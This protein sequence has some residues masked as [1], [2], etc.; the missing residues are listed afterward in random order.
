MAVVAV[1]LLTSWREPRDNAWH[2]H[3]CERRMLVTLQRFAMEEL[4]AYRHFWGISAPGLWV[5][6]VEIRGLGA[7]ENR[8]S[9]LGF[10]RPA[11]TR[12]MIGATLSGRTTISCGD[13]VH[14]WGP[15]KV[16]IFPGRG[17][18]R[19]SIAAS[20]EVLSSII[21]ETDRRVFPAP[22]APST[23][24]NFAAST[25]LRGMLGSLCR[26]IE[27]AWQSGLPTPEARLPLDAALDDLLAFLWAE[28]VLASRIQAR[29]LPAIPLRMR[30]VG[31]AVDRALSLS[32]RPM[33][34]DMEAGSAGCARTLQRAFP[35]LCEVWGQQPESFRAY[36][37]RLVLGR[38]L[39]AMM[40]PRATTMGVASA[41]GFSSPSAFCRAVTRAGLPPPRSLRELCG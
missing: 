27:G 32:R 26:A 41:L 23:L 29:D 38:A 39:S 36:R 12:T 11:G 18:F 14:E 37:Q 19:T 21:I 24:E 16:G 15:G 13:K 7:D 2:G 5:H 6:V 9:T 3:C 8:V 40:N 30:R 31:Q 22:A 33:M 4:G 34:V 1:S 35:Q 28:G 10:G 20:E 17:S 25:R